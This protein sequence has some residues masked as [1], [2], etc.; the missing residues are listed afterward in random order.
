[1]TIIPFWKKRGEDKPLVAFCTEKCDSCGKQ[2]TRR[3][4]TG[5]TL[6]SKTGEVC[7]CNGNFYV[8]MIYG[9]L[10]D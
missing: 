3:F 6:F 8:D 1:M 9:K 5:D 10:V 2:N 7:Q 4:K